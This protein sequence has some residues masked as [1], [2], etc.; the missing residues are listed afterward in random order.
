MRQ[1]E[2]QRDPE[3]SSFRGN[4]PFSYSL[5]SISK[6]TKRES[7]PSD[8]LWLAI[9]R[10]GHHLVIDHHDTYTLYRL[11]ARLLQEWRMQRP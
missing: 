1:K 10:F 6:I 3:R 8:H 7:N 5:S 4:D 11:H 9:Q 2:P